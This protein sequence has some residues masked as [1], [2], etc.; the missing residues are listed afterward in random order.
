MERSYGGALERLDTALTSGIH[1]SL[2]GIRALCQAL[3]DPQLSFASIQVAGTNGKSSTVRYVEAL[4]R[5]EG[6]RTALYTSPHLERY[7]ERFELGGTVVSDHLFAEAVWSALD[8]AESLRPETLGTS[9]GFTEFELLTAAALWLFAREGTEIAVL[10]VGLGGRWDA[11]SVVDPVVA[12]ITGIGLDH[13]HI[14]GDTL[15]AIAAEKAAIIGAGTRPVFGP[16]T[17][18]VEALLLALAEEAGVRP[19]LVRPAGSAGNDV[20]PLTTYEVL[21]RPKTPSGFTR[22]AIRGMYADYGVCEAKGPAY[23]AANAATAVGVVESALGRA[24]D[25]EPVRRALASTCVPGRF[26]LVQK[27]PPVVIDGSHN[28]QAALVLSEAI[29]DAWPH[30]DA[31]PVV[32]LGVLADKDA[33]GIVEALAPVAGRFAVTAP[34]SP[35]AMLSQ[36]LALIVRS[37]TGVAPEVYSTVRAALDALAASSSEGLVVTGSLITAGEARAAA[38]WR[39]GN[40]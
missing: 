22:M 21:E 17:V 34:G 27:S 25:V 37:V 4:L 38:S 23:Q 2:D 7:P 5:A 15:E 35:R 31:R 39:L 24:L 40:V 1:P 14:L 30:P 3:G 18:V 29:A 16:G 28:P 32:L 12:A 9:D 33:V 13:T 6:V 10:E 36:D 19:V 20:G 11:T 8:A 26:E